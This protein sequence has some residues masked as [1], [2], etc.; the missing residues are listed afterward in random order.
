MWSIMVLTFENENYTYTY[1]G[2]LKNNTTIK[3]TGVWWY[4]SHKIYGKNDWYIWEVE[5]LA[6]TK[7]TV[8]NQN[9]YCRKSKQYI[10]I[11]ASFGCYV[12]FYAEKYSM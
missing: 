8:L 6:A 4:L 2:N 9:L 3:S 7:T 1:K 12:D 10:V 5:I 11:D